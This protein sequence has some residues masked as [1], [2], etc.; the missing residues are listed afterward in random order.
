MLISHVVSKN[1]DSHKYK[2]FEF[3]Y[4]MNSDEGISEDIF[5]IVPLQGNILRCEKFDTFATVISV[6]YLQL[7]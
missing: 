5:G 7:E 3:L 1:E 4:E 6:F 2:M